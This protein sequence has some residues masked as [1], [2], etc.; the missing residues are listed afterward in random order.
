MRDIEEDESEDIWISIL[1]NES[2]EKNLTASELFWDSPKEFYE[3]N[4]NLILLD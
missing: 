1:K 2:G 3:R 4:K